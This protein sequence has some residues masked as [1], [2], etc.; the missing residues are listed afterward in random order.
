[1][2]SAAK[3]PVRARTRAASLAVSIGAGPLRRRLLGEW[4]PGGVFFLVFDFVLTGAGESFA[5][6]LAWW[7]SR[8]RRGSGRG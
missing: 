1:M 8:K 2:G 4:G 3:G 7:K 6:K 5:R